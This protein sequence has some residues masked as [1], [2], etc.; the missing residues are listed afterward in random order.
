MKAMKPVGAFWTGPWPHGDQVVH[1][2]V[3]WFDMPEHHGGGG[4]QA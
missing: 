3:G 2:F 1:A 4:G